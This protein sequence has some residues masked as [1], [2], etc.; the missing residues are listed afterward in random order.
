MKI[1]ITGG[2]GFI[3]TE[4][5]KILKTDGHEL[6][7]IDVAPSKEFPDETRIADITDQEALQGALEGVE[8]IYHLAAEHRDDVLP[9]QKYYDVNVGGGKNVIAAA[10]AHDIERIIFTST[11]AVY[12]LVPADAQNGSSEAHPPAPFNDYGHSK[13]QS[14]ATFEAWANEDKAWSLTTLRLVATFGPGNRGNI[15]TL[16]NQIASGK[17]VMIGNGRNRKS[18]AYV[19]N[20]A[21]FLAHCLGRGPGKHLYNYADK[22]D[23]A[24]RDFVGSVRGALGRE[25]IGPAFPYALG[26]LGGYAFDVLAKITGRRFP[27]SSIRVKKFCA[28]TVVNA[29]KLGETGFEAPYSLEAGLEEMVAAEFPQ[30][31]AV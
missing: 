12:P 24:M 23:L 20:V 21:A 18:I 25:G 9:L 2:A 4:L 27:I 30:E 11:V 28:S 6:V 22:P 8:A 29:E 26:L 16:I 19:G 5:A 13:L 14:E 31:K 3:G 10:K 15:F 1:A 7:L 17:F